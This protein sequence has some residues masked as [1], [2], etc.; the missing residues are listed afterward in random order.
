M[1]A[2]SLEN[3]DV[4]EK[5]TMP[6]HIAQSIHIAHSDG[7]SLLFGLRRLLYPSSVHQRHTVGNIS[8]LA[9]K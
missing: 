6:T 5:M 9:A 8:A 2:G 1:T 4:N 3:V 7:V